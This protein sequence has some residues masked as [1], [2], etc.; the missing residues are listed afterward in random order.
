MKSLE[1]WGL[2]R[3][4][5]EE[6]ARSVSGAVKWRLLPPR[7]CDDT[8]PCIEVHRE[9]GTI[10]RVYWGTQHERDEAGR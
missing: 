9:D 10:V 6:V 8:D 1:T 2:S 4:E 5:C 3:E 7:S